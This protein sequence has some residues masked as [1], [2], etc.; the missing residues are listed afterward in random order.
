[1]G[2]NPYLDL[3]IAGLRDVASASAKYLKPELR[4]DILEIERRFAC[5]GLS[6]LT[7]T[8][9]KLGKAID[10]ALATNTPLQTSGF[11]TRKSK[12]PVFLGCL[13][14][15]VFDELGRERSDASPA[16]VASLRQIL[17][18]CYKLELPIDENLSN[19]VISKFQETDRDLPGKQSWDAQTE[20]A[21]EEARKLVARVLSPVDP[22]G[23]GFNPRHGTGAVATGEKVYEK[24]VFKRYYR[25]LAARFPYED[26]FYYNPTHLCDEL[27]AFLGLDE[28]EEGTAKVVLVPKDSRGPRLISCEP[29][30]YMWIQQGLM[31]VLV[32]AIESSPLTA[33]HVNFRC[34]E[35]NRRLALAGSSDPKSWVTLDMKDASDRVSLDLVKAV[36]P[37]TWYAA[38]SAARSAHTK[39]PCGRVVTLNRFAPMGSAVCFPVE[40][41]VFWAL[42]VVAMRMRSPSRPL[43]DIL[44]SVFVYG[45]DIIVDFKDQEVVRQLLPKVG[46]AFNEGKCCVAGSFRESCGLDAYKGVQVTPLRLKCTWNH[47]LPGRYYVSWVAHANALLRRGMFETADLLIKKIQ[48]VRKT[49]YSDVEDPSYPSFNDPRK[50]ARQENKKLGFQRRYNVARNRFEIRTWLARSRAVTGT[51]HSGW[52]EMQRIASYSLP[53]DEGGG[54]V[55]APDKCNSF[56]KEELRLLAFDGEDDHLLVRAYRYTLPR[57]VTLRRG[58]AAE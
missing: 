16:A 42:S 43:Q 12:I 8:L 17:M 54:L 13:L 50:I 32:K 15:E 21:V 27:H 36:F 4:R 31:R 35:I 18:Y 53:S 28:L 55:P 34:Q 37:P 57:Q 46:L 40:A 10:L 14:R 7:R 19:E 33:G 24:P 2:S 29:L 45:D 38:L 49:P 48:K 5:E 23:A 26:Y 47:C 3:I 58:W 22:T 6:F 1:V 51:G 41:L 52:S 9:P 39:L 56:D 11:S 44:G 20:F 25:R 30:E